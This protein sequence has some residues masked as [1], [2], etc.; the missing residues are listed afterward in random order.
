MVGNLTSLSAH[1]IHLA[2]FGNIAVGLWRTVTAAP[3]PTLWH[4][5]QHITLPQLQRGKLTPNISE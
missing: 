4:R 3:T 5:E 1:L 2:D